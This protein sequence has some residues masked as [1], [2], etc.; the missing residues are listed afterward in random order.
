MP[1]KKIIIMGVSGVCLLTLA[2]GLALPRL[3][4]QKA[5]EA[6]S[7]S[8]TGTFVTRQSE[9][10][11]LNQKLQQ[12]LLAA[13]VAVQSDPPV[14]DETPADSG[15]TTLSE[16]PVTENPPDAASP[17]EEV[18]WRSPPRQ[19]DTAA[20]QSQGNQDLENSETMMPTEAPPSRPPQARRS[21]P[22]PASARPAVQQAPQPQAFEVSMSENDI[23]NLV[24]GQLQRGIDPRYRQALQGVSTRIQQ[25]KARVTVALLPKHLPEGFLKNLPGVTPSTPTVYL[26]GEMSLYQQGSRVVADVHHIS[27]G[28]FKVPMPFIQSAVR[29]Q[30]EAYS[31]QMLRLP[32]GRQ[33]ELYSVALEQGALTLTGIVN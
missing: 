24:Y 33:A 11:D 13:G 30:V 20:S 6:P 25:G 23:S 2:A 19:P 12:S 16:T 5:T 14:E 18:V 10:V 22:P 17:E 8:E 9:S 29:S 4:V 1:R 28:N 31:Q 27:L 3:L 7:I 32:D 21:S 15:V 26:G